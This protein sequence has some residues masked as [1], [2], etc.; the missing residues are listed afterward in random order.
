ML[1]WVHRRL[2]ELGQ[3]LEDTSCEEQLRELGAIYSEN[4]EVERRNFHSTKY[5]EGGGGWS[6]HLYK[7]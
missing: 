1:G 4:E 7:R 2:A 5:L 3:G 6:F